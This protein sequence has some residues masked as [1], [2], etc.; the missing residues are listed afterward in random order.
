M[1]DLLRR[2]SLN[3]EQVG[4]LDTLAGSTKT[5][6]TILN[7]ILD[8]SKIEAG[9]IIFEEAEFSLQD[10]VHDT[11]AL[12]QG[13]ASAKNLTFS[14][15][16][17][18]DLP[19]RVIGDPVRFRQLLFNLTG[20]AIKFTG[21]GGVRLGFSIAARHEGGITLLV[22]IRDT[23][24][25][26][27]PDQLPLLFKPF[28]QLGASTTRR[29]GGTGLGLV[30]THRLAGSVRGV[31]EVYRRPDSLTGSYFMTSHDIGICDACRRN[32]TS[33]IKV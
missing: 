7:D 5:L 12:F 1:A 21:V 4:Y 27:A 11:L 6:L 32:R 9:K 23:G 17:P 15:D 2:T 16:V 28:S 25:G 30:I 33:L 10:A 14:Y 19:P 29:F 18:K 3:E 24:P 26:I 20:N 8:I 13:T 22:E 31:G